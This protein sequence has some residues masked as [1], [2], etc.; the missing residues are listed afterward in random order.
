MIEKT[1]SV[2]T[3]P[4][5]W[6]VLFSDGRTKSFSRSVLINHFWNIIAEQSS[7]SL[8]KKGKNEKK[9]KIYILA[10]PLL[11]IDFYPQEF[12]SGVIIKSEIFRENEIRVDVGQ[13]VLG[14]TNRHLGKLDIFDGESLHRGGHRLLGPAFK[15]LV[16][17]QGGPGEAC[18]DD[19]GPEKSEVFSRAGDVKQTVDGGGGEKF[20]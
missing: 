4:V 10:S 9:S 2:T 14:R 18:D 20:G 7:Q 1:P 8:E 11:E 17:Q 5:P 6:S 16:D 15:G 13:C 19:A 3:V 12:S